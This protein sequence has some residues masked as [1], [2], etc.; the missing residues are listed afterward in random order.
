MGA[1]F[2]VEIMEIIDAAAYGEYIAGVKDIVEKNGGEYVVRSNRVSPFF[3][4]PCPV[5]VIM[6]RFRD[7]DGLERCFGSEEYKRIGPLR[8]SSTR[9]NACIV[10]ED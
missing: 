2:L 3:G 10:E 7:R 5:R 4:G 1:Y 8:E 9:A 6:I